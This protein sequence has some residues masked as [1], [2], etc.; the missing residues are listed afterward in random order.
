MTGSV[1]S[2]T[3][4]SAE[5]VSV[6]PASSVTVI[7]T[8]VTP[9]PTVVPAV[10]VLRDGECRIAVVRSGDA[11]REVRHRGFARSAV[12]GCRLTSSADADDRVRILCDREVC[13]A[14]IRVTGI[15]C[16][17]D[18]YRGNAWSN[19]RSGCRVLRDGECRVAVVR[20]R[21]ART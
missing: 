11:R 13:R 20:S 21:H 16:D 10:R 12:S 18:R 5:H 4:K 17:R 2:V 3:V 9:R 1:S 6:L 19:D 14:G 7:V 15:V 8:E